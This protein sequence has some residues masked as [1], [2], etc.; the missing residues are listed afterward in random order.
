MMRRMNRN[1]VIDADGFTSFA[2][3]IWDAIA[4][5]IGGNMQGVATNGYPA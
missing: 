5:S 2:I 1:T 3:V 4:K